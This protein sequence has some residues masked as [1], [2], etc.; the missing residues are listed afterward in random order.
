[1][2]VENGVLTI[3]GETQSSTEE[4]D[5]PYLLQ[6]IRRGSFSRTVSLPDG[7]EPDRAEAHFQNGML[8]L[9]IPKA[10]QVKPRQIRIT[11]TVDGQSSKVNESA[12]NGPTGSTPP[13][14]LTGATE[15]EKRV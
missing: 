11:P 6:E 3:S 1:V 10:E 2:T 9:R 13:E 12:S 15:S 4:R 5:G 8:E 14:G 7:L